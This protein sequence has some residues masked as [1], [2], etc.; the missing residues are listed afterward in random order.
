M[1]DNFEVESFWQRVK[2]NLVELIEFLAVVGVI[3]LMV[4]AFVAEPHQ[5]SGSSMVPNFLDGEFIITNKLATRFYG[6]KRGEIAIFKSPRDLG[7]VFIKRVIA[8][9][10]DSIKILGGKIYLN[11]TTLS[12]GYLPPGTITAPQAFLAEGEEIIIPDD[13]YF[14]IGDNRSGSSDSREWGPVKREL[15]I[16]QAWLRYWPPPKFGLI[17]HAKL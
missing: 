3:V 15:I 9:P 13:Q 2:N 11:K 17:E 16:G 7:K 14:F 4:H 10:G 8:L 12:E 1:E 5:V 6:I